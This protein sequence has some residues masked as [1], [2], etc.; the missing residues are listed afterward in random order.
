MRAA[1]DLEGQ[2]Q[3]VLREAAQQRKRRAAGAVERCSEV[4]APPEGQRIMGVEARRRRAVGR[5]QQVEAAV[6]R[7]HLFDYDA[8]LP[9]RPHVVFSG[10]ET[11]G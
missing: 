6:E 1:G 10:K 7:L 3:T 5:Y 9:A 8:S 11:G 2:R 4:R